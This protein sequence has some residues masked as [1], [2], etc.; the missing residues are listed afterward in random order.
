M[1]QHK[2]RFYGISVQGG[3]TEPRNLFSHN[4]ADGSFKVLKEID[5][6]SDIADP[7][8]LTAVG[9]VLYG[10]SSS[11]LFELS[12]FTGKYKVIHKFDLY[13]GDGIHP[14]MKPLFGRDGK[15]HG[16]T[17]AGGPGRV[18]TIYSIATDGSGYK[19]TWAFMNSIAP[20]PGG[21]IADDKG[22]FYGVSLDGGKIKKQLGRGTVFRLDAKGRYKTL[23]V[24][25]GLPDDGDFT[26]TSL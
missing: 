8:A 22:T 26:Y 2:R 25:T 18:G 24:F 21:L 1:V 14:G 17:E 9:S 20:S 7:V 12:L 15:L 16:T 13:G 3:I 6:A 10:V 4:L 5:G 19:T 23:H 11:T